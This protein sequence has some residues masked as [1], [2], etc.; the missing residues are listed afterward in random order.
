MEMDVA[1][2]IYTSVRHEFS[3]SHGAWSENACPSRRIYAC[4]EGSRPDACTRCPPAVFLR[5]DYAS[6]AMWAVA[7]P[8]AGPKVVG[9]MLKVDQSAQEG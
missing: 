2:A 9:H 8:K 7:N 6:H 3:A 1:V 4:S 5:C